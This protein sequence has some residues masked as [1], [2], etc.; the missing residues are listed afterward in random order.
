MLR[1]CDWSCWSSTPFQ[2][3]VIR[4]VKFDV[5]LD[6]DWLSSYYAVIDCY[7]E[8][9]TMCTS[10]GDY[11]YFL[12]HRTNRLLPLLYDPRGWSKLSFL[13]A[14][15]IDDGSD[16]VWGAFPKV[17]SEYTDVFPE[18]LTKLLPHREVEFSIDLVPGTTPI[19]M[20]P[21]RFALAELLVLKE[22]LQELLDK[23]FICPSTSP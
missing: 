17:V 22:Q 5:I 12:R 16:I 1:V 11:F 14:T 4:Y 6:M 8:R 10:G 2:F 18:N 3:C 9:V 15:F 21:Y 20:S 23:G 13:L 19:S 7:C